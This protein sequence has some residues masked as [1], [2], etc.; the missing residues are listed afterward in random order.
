MKAR[1]A[2]WT[3]EQEEQAANEGIE[4]CPTLDE[5]L[6]AEAFYGQ[7]MFKTGEEF[8]DALRRGEIT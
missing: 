5:V 1:W 8:D 7:P 3:A 6:A 2:R 4:D